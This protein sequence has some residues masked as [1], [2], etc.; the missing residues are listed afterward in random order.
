MF[1]V[2]KLGELIFRLFYPFKYQIYIIMRI[3]KWLWIFGIFVSSFIWIIATCFYFFN[4]DIRFS[5]HKYIWPIFYNNGS[6]SYHNFD[7]V[8]FFEIT[9]ETTELNIINNDVIYIKINENIFKDSSNLDKKYRIKITA[10]DGYLNYPFFIEHIINKSKR[11]FFVAKRGYVD[12]LDTFPYSLIADWFEYDTNLIPKNCMYI[13][14]HSQRF[15][16]DDDCFNL[17]IPNFYSD[18]EIY[19]NTSW[20]WNFS[21]ERDFYYE[22]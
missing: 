14:K 21:I 20:I 13:Q 9:E 16:W 1:L 3:L 4:D 2:K 15:P 5:L 7:D 6:S 10:N 11:N 19:I 22:Y 18:G 12:V 8:S 17:I